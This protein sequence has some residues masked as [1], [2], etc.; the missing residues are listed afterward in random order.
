MLKVNAAPGKIV[1][2]NKCFGFGLYYMCQCRGLYYKKDLLIMGNC[3]IDKYMLR[4]NA[5]ECGNLV[6]KCIAM[7]NWTHVS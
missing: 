5:E 3:C 4:F 2:E 6:C 1:F 7:R